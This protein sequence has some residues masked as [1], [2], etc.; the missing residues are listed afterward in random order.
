M[1]LEATMKTYN[2]EAHEII[3]VATIYILTSYIHTNSDK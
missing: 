1:S 2:I 3:E